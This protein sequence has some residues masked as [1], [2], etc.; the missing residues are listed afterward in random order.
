M[1][2][3]LAIRSPGMQENSDASALEREAAAVL[4]RALARPSAL[5]LPGVRAQ[6]RAEVERDRGRVQGAHCHP[7]GRRRWDP[8]NGRGRASM[9]VKAP[10]ARARW[11]G[12][13]TVTGASLSGHGS[14]SACQR[15]RALKRSSDIVPPRRRHAAARD[16]RPNAPRG[17][18]VAYRDARLATL[19]ARHDCCRPDQWRAASSSD[20]DSAGPFGAA[21]RS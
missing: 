3:I 17:F 13:S 15:I 6:H 10:A 11:N 9:L 4:D 21:A 19:L 2:S 18:R 16:G 7:R 1:L 8:W 5:H 12:A 20:G 14:A